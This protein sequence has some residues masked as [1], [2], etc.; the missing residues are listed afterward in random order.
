MEQVTTDTSGLSELLVC[1]AII[2]M[3]AQHWNLLTAL[4]ARAKSLRWGTDVGPEV[5]S[6]RALLVQ[7]YKC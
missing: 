7:K 5:L 4:H 6:L 1:C 3:D 2:T